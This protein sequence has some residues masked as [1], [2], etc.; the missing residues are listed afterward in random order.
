MFSKIRDLLYKEIPET[1]TFTIKNITFS[2]G[3]DSG[4]VNK[5]AD[6]AV[7]NIAREEGRT[8]Y[9]IKTQEECFV[10][11]GIPK[12][13]CKEIIKDLGEAILYIRDEE[14]YISRLEKLINYFDQVERVT[15]SEYFSSGRL[16]Y[17]ISFENSTPILIEDLSA[18][19]VSIK[20]SF[21]RLDFYIPSSG[22]LSKENLELLISLSRKYHKEIKVSKEY[23]SEYLLKVRIRDQEGEVTIL[24]PEIREDLILQKWYKE[25]LFNL[26]KNDSFVRQTPEA[27]WESL[28][29]IL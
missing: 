24:V 9:M 20:E 27:F 6:K 12:R 25:E 3:R 5:F 10:R 2:L 4:V 15:F 23:L 22:F 1:K 26:I 11:Y 7:L 19:Y 16:S 28:L 17:G 14:D 13:D 29:E 21:F 18:N 8:L